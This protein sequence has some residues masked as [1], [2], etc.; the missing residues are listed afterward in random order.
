VSRELWTAVDGYIGERLI[1]SDRALDAALSR[2][3]KW[4][5]ANAPRGIH[6]VPR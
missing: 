2:W 4:I 6:V 1:G 3:S 5:A